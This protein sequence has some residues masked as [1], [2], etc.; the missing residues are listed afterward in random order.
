VLLNQL[1]GMLPDPTILIAIDDCIQLDPRGYASDL[2]M[3]ADALAAGQRERKVEMLIAA[4]ELYEGPFLHGFT[5]P[6]SV[7]F[8]E[9][10]AQERRV[11][12][13]RYLQA[14]AT[15][16][17][18]YVETGA[19][20]AAIDAAQRY[21]ATDPLAE[22]MHR[23]LIELYVAIGDRASAVRQFKQCAATLERELDIGPMP[24]TVA[25]YEMARYGHQS[26]VARLGSV[27]VAASL[28]A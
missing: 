7:E 2:V 20:E 13:R 19:T 23:R 24:Q 28:A 16:I 14:L 6:S 25:L 26:Q 17:D 11:W 9:W 10:V 4:T 5:L 22:D 12:E 18:I 15:L 8:E 21:L 3:F 27:R 1:R